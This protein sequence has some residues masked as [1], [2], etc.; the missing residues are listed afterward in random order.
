LTGA[1]KNVLFTMS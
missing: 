1:D